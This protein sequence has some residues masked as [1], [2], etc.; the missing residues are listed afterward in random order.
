MHADSSVIYHFENMNEFPKQ[1]RIFISDIPVQQNATQNTG[2]QNHMA[3]IMPMHS[4]VWI[5][6]LKD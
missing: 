4:K 1:D 5:W 6:L 3:T 2:M